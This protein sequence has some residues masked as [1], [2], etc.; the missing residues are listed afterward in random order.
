MILRVLILACVGVA[1]EVA[2]TAALDRRDGRLLGYSY[3]WMF[4]VYAALYPGFALLLPFIE[5]W[6][7]VARGLLYGATLLLGELV[8]GLILRAALGQAPWE[9]EYRGKPRVVAGLVRLDFFPAWVA[10]GLF[11][12]SVF[13]LLAA[14]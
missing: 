6:P 7:F 11:F 8:F 14:R 3:L 10:A 4:P 2:F 9:P 13:R 12:E 5:T 1:A